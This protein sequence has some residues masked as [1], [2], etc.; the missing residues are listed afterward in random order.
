MLP[1]VFALLTLAVVPDTGKHVFF[2]GDAGLIATKGNTE[3][4]SVDVA[5]KLIV[6]GGAW[7]F[8]QTAG[9]TY[10]RNHDSVTAELWR[11]DLR[12]ERGLA[13]RINVYLLTAVE[14]NT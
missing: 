2:T 5:N 6:V 3:I 10:A 12:G 4:T 7:K 1:A 13:L 9:V 11:G 14:R 8:T